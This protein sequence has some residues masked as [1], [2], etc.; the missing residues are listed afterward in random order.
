MILDTDILIWYFRGNAKAKKAIEQSIPFSISAITVMELVQGT[1]NKMEQQAI[2]RQLH[3]WN[4]KI[5]HL[6]ESVSLRAIQLVNDFA[7]SHSLCAMDALIAGTAIENDEE[8][9]TGNKKHFEYV[10]GL[11]TKKFSPT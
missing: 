4:T 10:P 8:L 6:E 9:F 1:K 5:I 7:L 11:K 3:A 2:R